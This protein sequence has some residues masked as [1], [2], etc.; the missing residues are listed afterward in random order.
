MSGRAHTD[1]FVITLSCEKHTKLLLL[2]LL[3]IT[4]Q[5][6]YV[7]FLKRGFNKVTKSCSKRANNKRYLVP[8][9]SSIK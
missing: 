4:S 6:V 9:T 3:L 5:P 2:L 1:T 7:K 8:Q